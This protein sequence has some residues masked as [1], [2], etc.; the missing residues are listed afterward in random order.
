[1]AAAEPADPSILDALGRLRPADAEVLR[2]WAWED[3][4]PAEIAEALQISVNA[5]NLRLHRARQ[6]LREHLG[7]PDPASGHIEATEGSRP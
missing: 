6:R 3:L 1:M 7:K 2:L 4:G 5:A